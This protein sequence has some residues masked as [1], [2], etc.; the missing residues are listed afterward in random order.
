MS[1]RLTSVNNVIRNVNKFNSNRTQQNGPLGNRRSR[2]QHTHRQGGIK[3]NLSA[4]V[5]KRNTHLITRA[6][7]KAVIMAAT[8]PPSV[9]TLTACKKACEELI[10]AENCGP[11]LIRLAW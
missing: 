11:V 4:T 9:D 3:T 10:K 6:N 1:I 2:N 5:Q 8:A 7:N